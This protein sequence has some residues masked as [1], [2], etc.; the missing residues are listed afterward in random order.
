MA[1]LT[2]LPFVLILFPILVVASDSA[3]YHK[4]GGTTAALAART[5]GDAHHDSAEDC[6]P[7]VLFLIASS[8]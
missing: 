7:C 3:C 2:L 6:D 1:R 8:Y 5:C 4:R